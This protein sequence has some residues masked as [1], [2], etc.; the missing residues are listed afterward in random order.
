M[1][2]FNKFPWGRKVFEVTLDRLKQVSEAKNPYDRQCFTL[3]GYP[4]AFQV[5]FYNHV[6]LLLSFHL[7]AIFY[8]LM[9]SLY[10][11]FVDMDIGDFSRVEISVQCQLQYR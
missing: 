6:V 2:R 8:K 5:V 9:T 10:F 7:C 3:G 1:E 4:L 11:I